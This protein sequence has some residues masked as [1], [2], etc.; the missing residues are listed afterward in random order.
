MFLVI[1]NFYLQIQIGDYQKRLELKPFLIECQ[2]CDNCGFLPNYSSIQFKSS[3][4]PYS[5]LNNSTSNEQN[6]EKL[7]NVTFKRI[8]STH[9]CGSIECLKYYCDK[10]WTEI[11]DK[12]Q[13]L[14]DPDCSD[15]TPLLRE[16]YGNSFNVI[17]NQVPINYDLC[18]NVSEACNEVPK[19]YVPLEI[20][21]VSNKGEFKD[22]SEVINSEKQN[23]ER[24]S[25]MKK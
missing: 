23:A 21:K 2:P 9:F 7:T 22:I 15:H 3:E 12:I 8:P 18:K 4:V 13:D 19:D 11:H 6:Y 24:N 17:E 5:P 14:D 10:C 1:N 16:V 20:V 25:S